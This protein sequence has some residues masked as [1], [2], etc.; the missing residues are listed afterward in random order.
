MAANIVVIRDEEQWALIGRLLDRLGEGGIIVP[1]E[2][3][4]HLDENCPGWEDMLYDTIEYNFSS[5]HD[6]YVSVAKD[7][8]PAESTLDDFL[9]EEQ[10]REEW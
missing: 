4:E 7:E 10:S 3:C 8:N 9:I 6:I 2:K 5:D 1:P